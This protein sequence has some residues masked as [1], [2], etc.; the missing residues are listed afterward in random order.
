MNASVMEKCNLIDISERKE[1]FDFNSLVPD[2]ETSDDVLKQL[3]EYSQ[4]QNDFQGMDVVP[5]DLFDKI[6]ENCLSRGDFRSTF[7]LGAMANTGLR[8][9]DVVKLRRADFIDEHN[10]IRDTI[11]V[12]EKKTQKQ[13]L[14]FVNKALKEA[15]LMHL[16]NSNIAP[17]DYLITSNANNKG[18]ETETYIDENGKEKKKRINGKYVYK[19]DE[20]GNKIPKP[21]SRS[22]SESILK[23]IIVENLGIS[24]KNDWRCKDMD[25]A[26]DKICT[27]S[28]RKTYG[29]AITDGFIKLF[30]ASEAYAHTAALS[31]LSKDYGHSSEAM[32]MRYSKDLD[33][34]KRKVVAEMN[35][36]LNVLEKYF[37]EQLNLYEKRLNNGNQI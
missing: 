1:E 37:Q 33:N 17:M 8:Y 7:W 12:Q 28:L 2:V 6:V 29:A 35:I 20:N 21:L 9:S 18:Y 5:L 13:R 25:D 11:I 22:Q 16:W 31:F 27:H 24:L 19:L 14:V 10:K 23:R 26:K 30:D 36:G 4:K 3:E 32:T 34:L 15:L